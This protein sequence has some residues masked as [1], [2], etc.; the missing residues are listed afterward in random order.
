MYMEIFVE[1][2][3]NYEIF[4]VNIEKNLRKV[5]ENINLIMNLRELGKNSKQMS[6]EFLVIF[7]K[8]CRAQK[9]S[10]KKKKNK[11]KIR[12]DL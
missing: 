6:W 9:F 7:L 2:C 8:N 4:Q 5:W 10:I 11:N 1:I 12:F 3:K